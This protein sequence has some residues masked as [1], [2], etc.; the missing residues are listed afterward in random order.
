[1]TAARRRGRIAALAATLAMLV[2]ILLA[3]PVG[4]QDGDADFE[5]LRVDLRG[6]RGLVAIRPT[7]PSSSLE[8][9]LQADGGDYTASALPLGRSSVDGYTV[10][11]V[12]DSK[13]ADEVVGFSRVQDAAKAFVNGLSSDTR[14]ML[15]RGGGGN[16]E[17]QAL[18]PFTVNHTLIRDAIDEMRPGGGAVLWNSIA[19]SA[20]AFE[21]QSDARFNASQ[22][23]GLY[24]VV[25]VMA[26]PGTSSTIPASVAQGNLLNAN[27]GLT[28]VAP[29]ANLQISDY[30]EVARNVPGGAVYQPAEGATIVDSAR[31]AAR[32]HEGTL[33]L[34]FD[35][36]LISA[37]STSLTVS[38]GGRSKRIRV[39]PNSLA[40]GAALEAPEVSTPSR[41][42]IL[43]SDTA[44]IV[45]I[46]LGVAAALLFSFAM[47]QIFAG[48]D[49][50]LNSTLAVYGADDKTEE[51]RA[52][53][54]AFASVR[55][56]IVEQ[57]VERAESA[58]AS[59]GSLQSTTT[60]LQKA[61]IPLRVGEAMAVQVGIIL[62]AMAIGFL[63]T[64]SP[65][66]ALLFAIPG[67]IMPSSYVKFRVKRRKKR[68][69][70]QLPDTLN[71]L[72]S[73]LKAGYSFIQG[74]DAVGSE[75]EE[76]LAGEFRRTVNEARL[77]RDMDDALDDL[78]ERV[79]S[80]DLLWA[81][82]AIK[83]QREVGGN[84][85]ELLTTV[86]DT[87]VARTRL[88]GEVQA[89]T[90]EGRM[91]AYVLIM[92]PIGVGIAM[93]FMNPEYISQLW[94]HTIGYVAI[95]LGVAGM[96]VGSLWM[97]KII[98]IKI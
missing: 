44:A 77:G 45:A 63:L 10:L 86:A 72:A 96:V 60:M 74:M 73:T 11:V 59:R 79:G 21:I 92:L 42:D 51:Q 15:V 83:I 52:A 66:G 90:A 61:E 69:E 65:V 56:R 46:S 54:D 30:I 3:G 58:A 7:S 53:E 57:V 49:N 71:L 13:T 25:V 19:R 68:L 37:D 20:E 2:S 9:T 80:V 41:F 35:K 48:N 40:Q 6:D 28:I 38:Y 4:A 94:S 84:L 70:A 34:E 12:D 55:S 26:S 98:D 91:S 27:A 62:L 78:A 97:R 18:V 82:V 24:N 17:V 81:I 31:V 1:M 67:A 85:A 16:P 87:M 64:G 88:R 47:L 95:G 33:V 23:D 43:Q 14:V 75:A 89:L 8:V 29:V 93:Y 76:P 32:V 50:S 39:L 5:V 22:A 36:S